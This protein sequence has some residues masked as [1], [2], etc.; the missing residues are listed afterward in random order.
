MRKLY[1]YEI[2][3]LN[4]IADSGESWEAKGSGIWSDTVR[5]W[6][7]RISYKDVAEKHYNLRQLLNSTN[8]LLKLN[9]IEQN[10]L[11]NL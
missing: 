7:R 11:S 5:N 10:K 9:E 4:E 3:A 2:Q 6:A 8:K 1:K